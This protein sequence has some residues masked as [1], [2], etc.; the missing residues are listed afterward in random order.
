MLDYRRGVAELDK[1]F[2]SLAPVEDYYNPYKDY[3]HIWVNDMNDYHDFKHP[4]SPP[5]Y[6]NT[7]S[8]KKKGDKFGDAVGPARGRKRLWWERQDWG[9]AESNS[10]NGKNR[11][12]VKELTEHQLL[13]LYPETPVYGLKLKQWSE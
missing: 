10:F 11:Q 13:L 6:Y 8:H 12:I 3:D 2:A 4:P 7:Q 1:P 9:Y 5:L